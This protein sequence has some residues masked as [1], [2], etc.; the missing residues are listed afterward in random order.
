MKILTGKEEIESAFLLDFITDVNINRWAKDINSDDTVDYLFENGKYVFTIDNVPV[1]RAPNKTGALYFVQN[2]GLYNSEYD[3]VFYAQV[4]K[5]TSRNKMFKTGGVHQS[6]IW[7]D[8]AFGYK[9]PRFSVKFLVA[10]LQKVKTLLMT[11]MKQTSFG[12]AMW[13][14]LL[15]TVYKTYDCYY[16][17]ASP[18]DAKC[19]IRIDT[20]FDIRHYTRD[21]V[22]NDMAYAYR[23]AFILKKGTDPRTVLRDPDKTLILTCQEAEELGAFVTPSVLT[24]LEEDRMLDEYNGIEK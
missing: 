11:D 5:S 10:L 4:Q 17:L 20:E 23:T 15:T 7:K 2:N 3:I 22:Q 21:I 1:Y 19:I 24:E 8:T 18:S 16:A 6:L 13:F 14:N 9:T 12:S